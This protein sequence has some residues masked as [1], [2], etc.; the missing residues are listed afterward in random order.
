MGV[1]PLIEAESLAI[2]HRGQAIATDIALRVARGEVLVLLGPN[3]AGKTTL[4]RTLLGLI[5]ALAGTVRLSGHDVASL[6]RTRIARAAALVPQALHAPFAFTARDVVFMARTARLKA[7]ARPSITDRDAAEAALDRLGIGHLAMRPVTELSG[8][9]RQM[10]LIARA[11]AQETPLMVLDEPAASLDWGNRHRLMDYLER[12]A[13]DG[14]GLILS[15]HEPDHAARLASRVLTI[16]VEGA[17]WTGPAALALQPERLARLYGL[18][19][20]LRTSLQKSDM[21]VS[22]V[23]DGGQPSNRQ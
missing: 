20:T 1:T 21:A 9:Q 11:L 6:S 3:G 10:V 16:D 2:G 22:S 19:L 12:V 7:F 17:T 13:A 5:P 15:T 4:F 8:G 14:L 18:P 23:A